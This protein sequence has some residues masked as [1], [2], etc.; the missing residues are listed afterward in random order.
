MMRFSPFYHKVMF[1]AV[2]KCKSNTDFIL[3]QLRVHQ[4]DSACTLNLLLHTYM[5]VLCFYYSGDTESF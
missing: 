3:S 2:K 5:Y 1:N 4:T